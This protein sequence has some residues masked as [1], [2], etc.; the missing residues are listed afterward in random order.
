[1]QN[2][3]KKKGKICIELDI[4]NAEFQI[5]LDINIIEFQN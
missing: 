1:M 5:K 3:Q 4:T 2:F